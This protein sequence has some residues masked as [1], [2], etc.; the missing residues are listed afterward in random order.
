MKHILLPTDFSGRSAI[1]DERALSL[2]ELSGAAVTYLHVIDEDQPKSMIA[3]AERE[4]TALFAQMDQSRGAIKFAKL[5]KIGEPHEVINQTADELDA[6]LMV[7][8]AH[9]KAELRDAFLGTTA[10]RTIRRSKIPALIVR[11]PGRGRY[12]RPIA[13]LDLVHNDL[14]PWKR[15]AALAIAET[16]DAK[17]VFAYEAGSFHLLRKVNR[18]VKGFEKYFAE[19]REKVLPS[20]AVAMKSLDL[21]PEQAELQAIYYTVGDTIVDLAKRHN[22]DLIVVGAKGKTV[23]DRFTLGSVSATVLRRAEIDVLVTPPG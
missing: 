22:G 6:D 7:L 8:G 19:E 2:A 14:D 4:A 11:Q 10:E 13:A 9:R 3:A 15:A 5:V 21:K 16:K 20:V 18:D 23:I 17:V 1:A 12:L